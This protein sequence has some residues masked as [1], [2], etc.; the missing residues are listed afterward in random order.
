MTW[1][2]A[3]GILEKLFEQL[4]IKIK[5]EKYDISMDH[6]VTENYN[7]DNTTFIRNYD[8]NEIIGILGEINQKFYKELSDYKM[9]NIF[10]IQLNALINA[11]KPKSHLSYIFSNYSVYPSVV[12]DISIKISNNLTFEEIKNIIYSTNK[13]LIHKI[14][15]FNEY[16]DTDKHNYRF[17]G[18]RITYNSIHK[19][20]SNYD[21]Q[22]ID[23]NIHYILTKYNG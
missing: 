21:L 11:L 12:R 20:L 19:T 15:L 2:H 9:I 3:K 18:I 17:I 22:K 13:K 8:N 5:W 4:Q 14:E 7:L 1:L 23:E 16:K 10:E 6:I